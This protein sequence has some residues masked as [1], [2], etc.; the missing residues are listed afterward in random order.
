MEG[1]GMKGYSRS[2]CYWAYCMEKL[3]LSMLGIVLVIFAIYAFQDMEGTYRWIVNYIPM[4]GI[5]F[6]VASGMN[7]SNM[8]VPLALSSGSTRK[9]TACGV[10]IMTHIIMLQ[11]WILVVICDLL[12]PA[13][14]GAAGYFRM[15]GVLF[16]VSC[17]IGNGLGAAILRFGSKVGMIIYIVMIFLTVSSACIISALC[18]IDAVLS[19]INNAGIFAAGI[20]FD[21]IM[22]I[23]FYLGIRKYEVRI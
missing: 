10:I 19:F 9:E 6:P 22:A 8:Q 11:L 1:L 20:I 15:C 13:M 21:V 18:S 4:F 17:G 2:I 5:I 3:F 23:A 14:Q 7:L 16:V 12:L